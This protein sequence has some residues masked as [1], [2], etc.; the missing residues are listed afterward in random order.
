MGTTTQPNPRG[1]ASTPRTRTEMELLAEIS[2]KL[3]RVV[4]VL[5]TQG[6]PRDK[7]MEILTAAGCESGFI[8]TLVGMTPSAVRTWQSRR[9]KAG[10]AP[11]ADTAA[12]VATA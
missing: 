11:E 8:G 2:G 3:D 7:Q 4:A 5:A 10:E 6:K 9:R 1:R 12:E